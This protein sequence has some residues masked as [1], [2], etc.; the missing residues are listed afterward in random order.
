MPVCQAAGATNFDCGGYWYHHLLWPFG[1]SFR[2]STPVTKTTTLLPRAG[3][4][5]LAK[6]RMTPKELMPRCII[7]SHKHQLA[8]NAVGLSGPGLEFLLQ[9]AGWNTM[10]EPF[11]I[12]VM[13]LEKTPA[14]RRAELREIFTQLAHT[15]EHLRWVDWAIQI[16]LSCPNG[17]LDPN[18]LIDE[19]L[20]ILDDAQNI[21]PARIPVAVKFGPEVHPSSMLRIA[22]HPRCDA[23]C[24]FNT[25]P[26][27]KQPT[28]AK[29]TPP[30]NWEKFFGTSNPA[31]SPMAKRFP[32]FAGGLSGAPLKPFLFEWVRAVT[33]LG[34]TK[35]I[36]AGGGLL[37]GEDAWK[38]IEAGAE[39]TSP[40]SI[41]FLAP[42][43]V[44]KMIRASYKAA[45]FYNRL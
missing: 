32:S 36:I 17:G 23:I 18:D 26:F 21:L 31:D 25:L 7:V 15:R 13:S 16:N 39:A 5:P 9:H 12:S 8:L 44:R 3:N 6:D 14:T 38:V 41:A 10:A 33:S 11:M 42:T 30:V 29:E 45:H 28:W 27:G 20:P 35:P 4:M 34:I 24:V 19:V 1:C 40:G 2:Y 43:Q 37:S 22:K